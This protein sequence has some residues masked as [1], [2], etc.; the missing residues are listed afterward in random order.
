MELNTIPVEQY[1][2]LKTH[3]DMLTDA[4]KTISVSDWKT[5]GELRK[6]ARDAYSRE[7]VRHS[8]N[9]ENK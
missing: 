1:N 3:S 8:E 7:R 5:A 4:L 9:T 2:Q 6:M